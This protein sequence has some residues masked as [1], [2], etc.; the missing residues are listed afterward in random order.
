MRTNAPKH[1]RIKINH[2]DSLKPSSLIHRPPLLRRLS[3]NHHPKPSR[4]LN[5]PLQQR[6]RNPNPIP[7]L[8]MHEERLELDT[9]DQLDY[10]PIFIADT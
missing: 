8:R 6:T 4:L 10:P 2:P 5:P 7:L 9:G 3:I 1:M